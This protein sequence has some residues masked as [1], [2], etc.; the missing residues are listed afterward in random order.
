MLPGSEAAEPQRPEGDALQREH[1]MPDGF[2]HAPHLAVAAFA[3]R[4]L[5]LLRADAA[6]AQAPGLCRRG[7]PVIEAHAGAQ[8][9]EGRSPTGPRATRTR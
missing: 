1:R 3:D 9:A 4:E 7:R 2:A 5:Q 8:R 6:G